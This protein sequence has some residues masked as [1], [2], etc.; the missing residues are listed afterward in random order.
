MKT[1]NFIYNQK[2]IRPD[3]EIQIEPTDLKTKFDRQMD[4]IIKQIEQN[5]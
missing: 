4:Y 1:P 2:G 3:I 5:K